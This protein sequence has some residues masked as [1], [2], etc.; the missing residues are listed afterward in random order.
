M[1]RLTELISGLAALGL[2]T[3]A[4]ALS[5]TIIKEE[6]VPEQMKWVAMIG[7]VVA[8]CFIPIAFTH[9]TCFRKVGA[10]KVLTCSIIVTLTIIVVI[11]SSMTVDLGTA[12]ATETYLIGFHMTGTGR[13]LVAQ[14]NGPT[15]EDKIR[16]VGSDAIPQVY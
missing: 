15:V 11:R 9:Q 6:I 13:S 1:S 14:C 3:A 16:C 7:T 10:R 5:S 8:A 12:A 2:S 4:T